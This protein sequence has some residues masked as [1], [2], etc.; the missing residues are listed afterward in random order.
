MTDSI[1]LYFEAFLGISSTLCMKSNASHFIND[2]NDYSEGKIDIIIDT[3]GIPTVI[4]DAINKLS[5]QGR[6]ILV[7]QPA[8]DKFV[9]ISNALNLF[10][11]IGKTIKATQGGK[12][13]PHLDIPR[14]IKLYQNDRLQIDHLFTDIVPLVEV[15]KG[16]DL[17]R[18]RNAGR[19]LV[20]INEK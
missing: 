17:L 3:T 6:M 12:T 7:G 18:S 8:P 14:Y 5:D 16:F 1:A 13:R 15:N 20:S 9:Q 11:G 10:N 4:T 2:I 19:V